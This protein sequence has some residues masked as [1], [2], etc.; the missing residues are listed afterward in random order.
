VG[1]LVGGLTGF[2]V[3]FLVTRHFLPFFF[4]FIIMRP[5]FKMSYFF[6]GT[7]TSRKGTPG[8]ATALYRQLTTLLQ[9]N[10]DTSSYPSV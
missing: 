7:L 3:G 4:H 5:L 6:D 9:R 8:V 2:L 1:I 10:P